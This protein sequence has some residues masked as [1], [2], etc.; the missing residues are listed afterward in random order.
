MDDTDD[1]RGKRMKP[2]FD[3]RCGN[4][5]EPAPLFIH[6]DIFEPLNV[7]G[8]IDLHDQDRCFRGSF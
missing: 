8:G 3:D 4:K 6:N 5:V 7:T 2:V 1:F